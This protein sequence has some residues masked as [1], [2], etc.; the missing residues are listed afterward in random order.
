MGGVGWMSFTGRFF[1]NAPVARGCHPERSEGSLVGPAQI[2]RCAQD[3]PS[4][5]LSLVPFLK[6]LP[7]KDPPPHPP[8]V[9]TGR[10]HLYYRVWLLKFIRTKVTARVAW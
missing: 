9:P 1:G 7:V 3:D 10:R 4:I 6:N 8:L 2:L 5:S